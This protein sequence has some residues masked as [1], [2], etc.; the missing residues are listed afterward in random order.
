MSNPVLDT[1]IDRRRVPA[2]DGPDEQRRGDPSMSESIVPPFAYLG[3]VSHG[4]MRAEDLV[5]T[6]LAVY[7]D[8]RPQ[9]WS[10]VSKEYRPLLEVMG[11][12]YV[13]EYSERYYEDLDYLLSELFDYLNACSPD[14]YYFGAI[15]GDGCDYG[16]WAVESEDE[17]E[18]DV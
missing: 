12:R 17:D 13:Q 14:G 3:T 2:I 7:R 10:D 18:S 5:P 9:F 8:L 6:F 11:S 1:K 15:E 4:T 16:F